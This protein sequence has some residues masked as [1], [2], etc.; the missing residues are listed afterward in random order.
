MVTIWSNKAKMQL[1]AAS[2]YIMQHSVQNAE[3]VR[4]EIIDLTINLINHPEKYPL[5]KYK[6]SNDGT[7][8]AFEIYHYRIRTKF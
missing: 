1:K 3:K 2:D 4:N 8:R 5:D 7:Y 6:I